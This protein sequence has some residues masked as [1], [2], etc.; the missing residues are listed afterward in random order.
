[1]VISCLFRLNLGFNLIFHSMCESST[2]K[3]SELLLNL[4]ILSFRNADIT[5]K[6]RKFIKNRITD[7]MSVNCKKYVMSYGTLGDS[8]RDFFSSTEVGSVNSS[9]QKKRF[10]Q[11]HVPVLK[12]QTYN[13]K[14]KYRGKNIRVFFG[15]IYFGNFA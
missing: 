4:L 7:H 1:M 3:W 6:L 14:E 5:M 2:I 10:R 8:L 13:T 12:R 15:K 11:V 9:E